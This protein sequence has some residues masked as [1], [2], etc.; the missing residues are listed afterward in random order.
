MHMQ[1]RWVLDRMLRAGGLD[2]LWPD[3]M[4][5]LLEMGFNHTDI[6]RTMGQVRT[7]AAMPKLWYRTALQHEERAA[8]ELAKG[9]FLTAAET[10]HRAVLGLVRARWG[11]F[12]DSAGKA[13]L[14]QRLNDNY[15]QVI[16]H[17]G[18]RKERVAV[19]DCHGVLHLPPGDGPFPAVVLYPGMDMTKEYLP[20]PGRNVFGARGM[21]VLSLDA[22]GHGFSALQGVKLT[23]RN[24]ERTG[25][26][27][28]DLLQARPE[29][30]AERVG[31]F[32]I[33]TGGYFGFSLAAEDDRVR[34]VVGLEG[35]FFYDN[36]AMLAGEPP[37]RRARLA[38]MAGLDGAE[39][40]ALM[41]EIS[42][43]G[44]E[45]LVTCP[46][47]YLVGEWDELT[48]PAEARRL[49]EAVGGPMELRIYEDE[50]HVLGGVM[51]EAMRAAVDWLADRFAGVPAPSTVD[52]VAASS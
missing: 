5:T 46:S 44:R 23:A 2:V 16:A 12:S 42:I 22:P 38:Y 50:G 13:A 40:D 34:A 33:G 17:G 8:A 19:G 36:V 4:G 21:A 52:I 37:S 45:K 18:E 31:V 15:D 20:V 7:M 25:S 39:L 43:A 10:Y 14:Y 3:V 27:A 51:H 28:T 35:G 32:G 30:D 6:T 29:I 1:E 41:T 11:M 24:V 26:R 47:M 49:A 48:P 9:H